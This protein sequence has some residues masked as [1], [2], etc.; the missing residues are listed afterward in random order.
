MWYCER[1]LH[2][3][4]ECVCFRILSRSLYIANA[5]VCHI[6]FLLENSFIEKLHRRLPFRTQ[7]CAISN[8]GAP[9]RRICAGMK[10]TIRPLMGI[11]PQPCSCGVRTPRAR[12]AL[13]GAPFYI[14]GAIISVN[15]N[16]EHSRMGNL[17]HAMPVQL[18]NSWK[19]D[20]PDI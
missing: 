2:L 12:S 10:R 8:D 20:F 18:A 13:F 19:L 16:H 6:T 7:S 3:R 4:F 11:D 5:A 17:F 9:R 1:I 14:L 15:E